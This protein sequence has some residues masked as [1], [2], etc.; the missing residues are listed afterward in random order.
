M[1]ARW[2][3]V[4][5]EFFTRVNQ[6]KYLLFLSVLATVALLSHPIRTV[7]LWD[8]KGDRDLLC[9]TIASSQ[10]WYDQSKVIVMHDC[11]EFSTAS[12]SI[13]IYPTK[14]VFRTTDACV[15]SFFRLN[16]TDASIQAYVYFLSDEEKTEN[17]R[18]IVRPAVR[19]ASFSI[20]LH[21]YPF[22]PARHIEEDFS[23]GLVRHLNAFSSLRFVRPT[24]IFAPRATHINSRWFQSVDEKM[25]T[26]RFVFDEWFV[27]VLDSCKWS[28]RIE[29][30]D[31]ID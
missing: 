5:K 14:R 3:Q 19:H 26:F 2:K 29:T 7:V 8:D 18:E 12:K 30:V 22:F 24:W 27:F 16:H 21:L 9:L 20:T 6:C 4:K 31:V 25:H 13:V 11:R 10:K 15:L 28:L 23:G 1:Q 17:R